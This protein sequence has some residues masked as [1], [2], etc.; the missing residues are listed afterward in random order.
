MV[1]HTKYKY[2]TYKNT[3]DAYMQLKFSRVFI[4]LSHFISLLNQTTQTKHLIFIQL[5]KVSDIINIFYRFNE[6]QRV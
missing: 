3:F 6:T 1:P 5:N 4:V 2:Y